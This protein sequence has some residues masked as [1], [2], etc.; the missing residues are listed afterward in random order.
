MP[1][2]FALFQCQCYCIRWCQENGILSAGYGCLLINTLPFWPEFFVA[3]KNLL[4]DRK[5]QSQ[6]M[7]GNF[8]FS[9]IVRNICHKNATCWCSFDIYAVYLNSILHNHHQI[10]T[11]CHFRGSNLPISDKYRL[12]GLLFKC[13]SRI[14]SITVT[15][16]ELCFEMISVS[17]I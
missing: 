11:T 10:R 8:F 5:T 14:I 6:R 9:I 13:A 2:I 12:P 15:T 16:L 1:R 4:L 7:F 3:W 17:V